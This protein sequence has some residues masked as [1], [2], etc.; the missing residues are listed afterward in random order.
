MTSYVHCDFFKF[1]ECKALYHHDQVG[2]CEGKRSQFLR[3]LGIAGEPWMDKATYD[4]FTELLEGPF[5]PKAMS[6]LTH[7]V[8]PACFWKDSAVFAGLKE[9]PADYVL[10]AGTISLGSDDFGRK[11]QRLLA[12][13][14]RC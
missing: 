9:D 8:D 5:V 2:F 6:S 14:T 4:C 13:R 10:S 7:E 1:D 3:L 11:V 12:L